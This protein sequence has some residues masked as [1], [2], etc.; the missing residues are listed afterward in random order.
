MNDLLSEEDVA[1]LVR[2]IASLDESTFDFLQLEVGEIKVTLGKG[3]P[4]SRNGF[5]TATSTPQPVL[6]VAPSATAP[7]SVPAQLTEPVP[8]SPSAA[9]ADGAVE[10]TSPIMGVFYAQPEPGAA[11]YVTVGSE[12]AADTTV[13]LVEVMKT[14]NA[15]PAGVA[16][17]VIEVCAANNQ[18]VE[19]GQAVFRVLPS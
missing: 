1:R 4:P 15:V 9:A 10:I 5:A 14:F 6:S 2:I 11:P 7:A 17:T 8:V 16:G 19:F 3:D 13:G 18:F 12:V